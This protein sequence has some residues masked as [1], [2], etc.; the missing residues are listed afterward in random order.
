MP[1]EVRNEWK[2]RLWGDEV[3]Q[4]F[5]ILP[6]AEPENRDQLQFEGLMSKRS[7]GHVEQKLGLNP[8]TFRRLLN[9]TGIQWTYSV[10]CLVHS[11]QGFNVFVVISLSQ[12]QKFIILCFI[13]YSVSL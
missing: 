10:Q 13:A 12:L 1:A 8:K 3:G 7:L 4:V 11:G 2:K 6:M 5:I 9:H